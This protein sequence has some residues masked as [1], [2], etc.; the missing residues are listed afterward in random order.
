MDQQEELQEMDREALQVLAQYA[1][2]FQNS[3]DGQRILADLKKSLDRP[4]YRPGRSTDEVIWREG[5]R[6]V[7]LDIVAAVGAGIEAIE[8]LATELPAQAE[9]VGS[10]AGDPLD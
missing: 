8:T 2:F 5:R 7:Y 1:S 9:G 4:T 6:S 3:H 10:V